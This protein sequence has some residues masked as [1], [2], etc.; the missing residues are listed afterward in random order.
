MQFSSG[1]PYQI[2][3][4]FQI[5]MDSN[6]RWGTNVKRMLSL[7]Y[8]QQ[9]KAEELDGWTFSIDA[10][11]WACL[12]LPLNVGQVFTFAFHC[13]PFIII[14]FVDF[15]AEKWRNITKRIICTSCLAQA[16]KPVMVSL[17]INA[18]TQ[19]NIGL[20]DRHD[21]Q[22]AVVKGSRGDAGNPDLF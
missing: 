13:A 9:W 1:F 18:D 5:T 22:N 8:H 12:K 16:L 7:L 2:A 21:L 17:D 20:V 4:G 19:N 10:H 6:N 3:S 11:M 15:F 14:I